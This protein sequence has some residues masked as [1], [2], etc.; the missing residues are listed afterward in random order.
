MQKARKIHAPILFLASV[1]RS[2]DAHASAVVKR[3][4]NACSA[5]TCGPFDAR[6]TPMPRTGDDTA[7]CETI[8]VKRSRYPYG[9]LMAMQYNLANAH[10]TNAQPAPNRNR[11]PE[12]ERSR[13]FCHFRRMKD[14]IGGVSAHTAARRGRS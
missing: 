6:V 12:A 3:S 9:R 14:E 5:T 8:F 4:N 1:Y 11:A 13:D 10:S 7:F 2:S